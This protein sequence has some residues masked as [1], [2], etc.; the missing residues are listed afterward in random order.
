MEQNIESK[1]ARYSLFFIIYTL[2]FYIFVS[3]LKYTLP[4][5]FAFCIAL[6]LKKPTKVL[7]H[8]F[9]ISLTIASLI[10]SLSFWAVIILLN[11]LLFSLMIDELF[12]LAKRVQLFF[13]SDYNNLNS[14]M[15]KAQNN[16]LKMSIDP[17]ILNSLKDSILSSFKDICRKYYVFK[18]SGITVHNKYFKIYTLYFYAYNLYYYFNI[19]Y[20]KRTYY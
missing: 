15:S 6:L 3:T 11:V 2:V 16:L 8:K 7:M 17:I 4:F 14:L 18:H 13:S 9:N 1:L 10:T 12:I 19:L 5:V 20:N